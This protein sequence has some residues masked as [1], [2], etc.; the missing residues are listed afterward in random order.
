MSS[1]VF[2]KNTGI[3]TI[4]AA[5]GVG[6]RYDII[7]G[8]RVRVDEWIDESKRW[9]VCGETSIIQEGEDSGNGLSLCQLIEQA[10][11]ER[12]TDRRA[13]T[14]STDGIERTTNNDAETACLSRNVRIGTSSGAEEDFTPE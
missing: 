7:E 5:S 1:D 6:A 2:L 4:G 3:R 11:I 13:S 10:H 9:L 12:C 14:S 8:G